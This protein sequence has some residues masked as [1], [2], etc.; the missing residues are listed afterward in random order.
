[1]HGK[2]GRMAALLDVFRSYFLETTG[3]D[4]PFVKRVDALLPRLPKE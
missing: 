2:V 3:E 4:S 1:M